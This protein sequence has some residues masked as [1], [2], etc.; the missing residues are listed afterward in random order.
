MTDA[1]TARI[2]LVT[3]GGTGIGRA[4]A[5][6]LLKNGYTVVISGRRADILQTA[7]EELAAQTGG[8]ARAFAADVGDPQSVATLFQAITDDFGRLDLLVNNAGMGLPAVPME[9][10]TF[11]QWNAI[12]AANLTGAFLCTQQAMKL[13]KAQT[14]RG[15]RIINN[16][17]ISAS[18][19]RPLSAP[20]TATKHAVAGLTKSTALDGRPFDIAC[21]QIDIGNASTEMTSR[22]SGGVLQANGETAS[23]PTIPAHLVADA[24]LYMAGLPLSANVL[25]M[26]VMATQMPYVG[27]G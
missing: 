23:E 20:Y 14:P 16:G 21:G 12:V 26:T 8:T 15:G 2:A 27:R 25:T 10:I 7:A 19:P 4:I 22:M 6:A 1:N 18:T 9:D 24:V 11:E 3:G 5:E 17:S 13:M